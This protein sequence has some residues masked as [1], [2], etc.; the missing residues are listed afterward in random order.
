MC[1]ICVCACGFLKIAC[2]KISKDLVH[3][4]IPYLIFRLE[5]ANIVFVPPS[6]PNSRLDSPDEFPSISYHSDDGD[7]DN[8]ITVMLPPADSTDHSLASHL[9]F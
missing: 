6:T 7:F 9:G 4:L 1:T 5:T 3:H 2:V 8:I